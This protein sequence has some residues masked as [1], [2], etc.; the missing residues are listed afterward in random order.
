MNSGSSASISSGGQSAETPDSASSHHKS[1]P[2]VIATSAPVRRMTITLWTEVQCVSASST[3][4]LSGTVF[5]PRR[6]SSAVI[7]SV[8]SQ[9]LIR[10]A[11]ASGEKPPKTTEWMAPIRAQANMATAASGTMGK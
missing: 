11:K 4:A 8:L 6:P 1:R 7:M 3:L 2:A 10:P 9:S 5:P